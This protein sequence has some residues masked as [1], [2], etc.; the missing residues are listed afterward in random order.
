MSVPNRPKV[1]IV[2]AGLG[3]ITLG[4]LLELA[5]VPYDIYERSAC[6]TPMGSSIALGCNVRRI[7]E[8]IGVWE[9]FV[10]L[11]K[12]TFAMNISNQQRERICQFDFR[13]QEE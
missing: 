4:I 13:G 9:E 1:L 8:Q 7:F 12:P 3:G 11:S 10:K 6:A 2:G 5:G